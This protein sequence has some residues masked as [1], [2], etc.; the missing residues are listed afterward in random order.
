MYF[1]RCTLSITVSISVSCLIS[2][3]DGSDKSYL[4]E[5]IKFHGVPSN[6]IEYM[7]KIRSD[8][9]CHMNPSLKLMYTSQNESL[10]VCISF[11]KNQSC[12][13]LGI[14]MRPMV[15]IMKTPIVRTMTDK[16]HQAISDENPFTFTK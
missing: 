3:C 16:I 6:T 10:L 1:L 13:S 14:V 12:L 2:D 9:S 4:V 7:K 5:R 15:I 8:E 11:F